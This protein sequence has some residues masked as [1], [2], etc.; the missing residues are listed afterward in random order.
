MY[1]L[2]K[3]TSGFDISCY[4]VKV[5]TVPNCAPFAGSRTLEQ[6]P[7]ATTEPVVDVARRILAARAV[8]VA[9]YSKLY[10]LLL[11]EMGEIMSD[12]DRSTDALPWSQLEKS[13]R[14]N[15]LAGVITRVIDC[16]MSSA[17]RSERVNAMIEAA[18]NHGAFRRR[19]G[20]DVHS[21]F[22]EYDVVRAATWRQLKTLVDAPTSYDAIF[23]IDGLLSVATRG[24]ILGFHRREMEENGLWSKHLEELK[25]TVRS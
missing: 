13:E 18:C 9:H 3:T 1:L 7:A 23:V 5:E 17:P 14:Q 6:Q 8:E 19:Q 16:A 25:K 15:D 12:W 2:A 10:P 22:R 20:V 21:I 24:T 11:A 4:D